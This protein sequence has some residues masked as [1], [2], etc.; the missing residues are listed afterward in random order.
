MRNII[1]VFN[2]Y[3][4]IIMKK[5]KLDR[6]KGCL[7]NEVI[8]YRQLPIEVM[9]SPVNKIRFRNVATGEMTKRQHFTCSMDIARL[10]LNLGHWVD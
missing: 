2:V 10:M 7:E 1:P 4:E 3:K 9:M 8:A 5:C 6:Q